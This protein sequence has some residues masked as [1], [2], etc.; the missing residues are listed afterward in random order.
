MKKMLCIL[1]VNFLLV[2]SAYPHNLYL[3]KPAPG[4]SNFTLFTLNIMTRSGRAV[5]TKIGEADYIGT[6]QSAPCSDL[7]LF[8]SGYGELE[9]KPGAYPYGADNFNDYPGPGYTC[10]KMNF[11]IKEKMYS[12]GNIQLTWSAANHSYIDANPKVIPIEIDW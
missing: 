6:S 3:F 4:R 8:T 12:T 10:F 11:Y 1:F 2:S 7:R 5:K 9:L